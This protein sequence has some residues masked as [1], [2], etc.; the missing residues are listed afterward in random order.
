MATIWKRLTDYGKRLWT[1]LTASDCVRTGFLSPKDATY[2]LHCTIMKTLDKLQWDYIV[3]PIL[4]ATLPRMGYVRNFFSRRHLYFRRLM[5]SRRLSSLPK[6]TPVPNA[7]LITRTALPTIMGD[8]I[9][10][11][12]EQL[13]LEVG[14]P[15][16]SDSWNW[17][18]IDCMTMECWLKEL[19]K[20]MSQHD[21]QLADTL[22][23]LRS[24]RDS[25]RFLMKEFIAHG[26]GCWK[27][28]HMTTLAEISSADG[29]Y[30]EAWAW[31]GMGTCNPINQYQWP[32]WPLLQPRYWLLWQQALR[33][34][35]LNPT[36]NTER[37]LRQSLGP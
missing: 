16:R 33:A 36:V 10:A 28:L 9:R 1:L 18:V 31:N 25:D 35:F 30:L 12:L 34:L 23:V 6:S 19:L 4:T 37:K 5:W 14:L 27:Y 29:N 2:T 7:D 21:F 13:R 32:R 26:Y 8:L 17:G 20:C 22:P 11:S 24:Y 3:A 15:G